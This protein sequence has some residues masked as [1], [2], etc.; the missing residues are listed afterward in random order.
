MK[1]LV[2]VK[3]VPMETAVPMTAEQ[4]IDRE[5]TPLNLNIADE[6]ALEAAF[7]LVK[8]KTGLSAGKNGGTVTVL[9]MGPASVKTILTDLIARGA[10]AAI[11]LSD[12][13]LAGAD[14]YATANTLHAAVPPDTDYI[15]TGRRAM[16]GETGQVPPMLAAALGWPVVTNVRKAEPAEKGDAGPREAGNAAPETDTA[17][18]LRVVRTTEDGEETL[19][20]PPHSVLSFQ[21]Y[22]YHL[23]LPG[24]LGRRRAMN[25]VIPV[26]TAADLSLPP[27]A[28]G[29][30]GSLTRV[31][32]SL[33]YEQ[34]LRKGPRTADPEEGAALAVR[35]IREAQGS[36]AESTEAESA[37]GAGT[38][39]GNTVNAVPELR[40]PAGSLPAAADLSEAFLVLADKDAD[41]GLISRAAALAREKGRDVRPAVRVLFLAPD[42]GAERLKKAFLYGADTVEV[43][44]FPETCA[45]DACIAEALAAYLSKEALPET[46]LAPASVL[47]RSVMPYLAMKLNAGLTADCT[48]IALTADRRLLQTRPAFGNRLLASILT[49]GRI[50]MATV[51]RGSYPPQ[52]FHCPG[53]EVRREDAAAEPKVRLLSEEKTMSLRL[54]EA[55]IIFT[56]GA[57]LGS[58]DRFR[59]FEEQVTAAGFTAGATRQAVELGYTAYP[60]QIGQ[61][62]VIVRPELVILFGVSGAVQHL[63]GIRQA[64]KIVAVNTDPK[65]PIFDYA[66]LG[67]Y[68]DWEDVLP[69]ILRKLKEEK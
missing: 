46:I 59:R 10:D 22:S 4:N 14:T 16:D 31:V 56:G 37:E 45:D 68:G 61:T 62:G 58:A 20:V 13:A 63:I 55:R 30:K 27:E 21:E 34:H 9:S 18:Y 48:E 24:I 53:R 41:F 67:I 5:K 28:C 66:D 47:F 3:A 6:A 32:K 29:L 65:A 64:K 33:R 23:R 54:N 15:F 26:R 42:P 51:R 36:A 7:S 40:C 39:A 25:A 35:M 1:I 38:A 44:H 43:L 12:P 19:L 57:G 69:R 52:V 8:P 49:T 2:P 11:L 50:R 17:P 60:H